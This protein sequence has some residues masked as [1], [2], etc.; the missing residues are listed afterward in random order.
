MKLLKKSN[1]RHP[2]KIDYQNK[3]KTY[4][5]LKKAVRND[6]KILRKHFLHKRITNAERITNTDVNSK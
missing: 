2:K 1:D 5:K 4:L 6:S 3:R